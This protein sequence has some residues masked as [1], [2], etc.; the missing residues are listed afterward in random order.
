LPGSYLG[1]AGV[2]RIYVDRDA[3]GYG[4][5]V[6]PTPARD[7]EFASS[8]SDRMLRAVDPRAV[9]RIDLLTVVEHELGHIAGFEDLNALTDN[10]MSGVLGGGVRRNPGPD[11]VVLTSA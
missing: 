11:R 9:D 10:L 4:W 2:N 3:A 7:E 1:E 8:S 5:V 6:D